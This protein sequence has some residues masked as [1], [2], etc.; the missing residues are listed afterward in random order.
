M[1]KTV[2]NMP[3]IQRLV[4]LVMPAAIAA[5]VLAWLAMA[6]LLAERARETRIVQNVELAAVMG[7]LVHEIQRERGRSAQFL[8][9]KG[10]ID[11]KELSKQRS[12]TDSEYQLFKQT[13]TQRSG[14]ELNQNTAKLLND[15]VTQISKIDDFRS[16]V[17]DQSSNV[18]S[19]AASY[20]GVIRTA[21]ITIE[22]LLT[23]GDAEEALLRF[24]LREVIEAKE[25]A[26]QERAFGANGFGAG[27]FS[28]PIYRNF[29][30]VIALQE[31]ELSKVLSHS[32]ATSQ[33]AL[34]AASGS[35][36]AKNVS[37]MREIAHASVALGNVN[38]N[39]GAEWWSATTARIDALKQVEN[40]IAET[41]KAKAIADK[42]VADKKLYL[43]ISALTL[44]LLVIVTSVWWI[45]STI[46][47]PLKAI[48][49]TMQAM[50]AGR[51]D[52]VIQLPETRDELGHVASSVKA[53]QQQLRTARAERDA[54]EQEKRAQAEEIV[55]S[56]G[57]GLKALAAGDLTRSVEKELQ[58]IFSSLRTDFNTAMQQLRQLMGS[59]IERSSQLRAG[60][61]EI[62]H[63]AEDLARRT[64]RNA[65][66]IEQTTAALVSVED[67]MKASTR[68]GQETV[69]K[70]DVAITAVKG[71]RVVAADVSAAMKRVSE[72]AKAIDDV[73]GGLD[74]ISFQTRVLAMNA[75]VEAARAGEA[76]RGFAVVADLVAALATRAEEE[77]RNARA[78][79]SVTRDEIDQAVTAAAEIDTSFGQ[80]NESVTS[81]FALVG[82][83]AEDNQTQ[84]STISEIT[85]AVSTLDQATQQNAAMVEETSAALRT[86]ND[87]L[88]ALSDDISTFRISD[89]PTH[90]RP[91]A[92]YRASMSIAAE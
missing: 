68:A 31:N 69:A 26:G 72:S 8:G 66:T 87:E 28:L 56:I 32:D 30:S 29:V 44:A 42:A 39:F 23:E 1:L 24:S 27:S 58:G 40:K 36:Y 74:K 85:I 71:G 18:A 62:A 86:L 12:K 64:E 89:S 17:T 90:G 76:G 10:Q 67:R 88:N 51:L 53:F 33:E 50:S 14:S 20:S 60:A 57:T 15:F 84:A 25:F 55:S 78:Q 70:A 80:I 59:L 61:T 92:G 83:M 38:G 54:Q 77:S 13:L 11:G 41:I 63:A 82:H 49:Q 73:I 46:V 9:A 19:M 91:S 75:A 4:L 45:A 7:N 6:G 52:E 21:I 65:A 79:L 81:V 34:K 37:R 22:S 5:L 16:N 35:A 43:L 2:Q 48:E 3:I 47:K